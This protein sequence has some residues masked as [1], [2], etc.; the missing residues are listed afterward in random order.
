[1]DKRDKTILGLILLVVLLLVALAFAFTY[2]V[3][4]Q[5]E[6]RYKSLEQTVD[7]NNSDLIKK[8]ED[9]QKSLDDIVIVTGKLLEVSTL[10]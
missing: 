8:I 10:G 2:K 5:S 7:S 4:E 1:M 3:A 9:I 6:A